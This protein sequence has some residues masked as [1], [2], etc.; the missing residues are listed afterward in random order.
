M[1][2][3]KMLELWNKRNFEEEKAEIMQHV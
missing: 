3:P 1:Q 2:E